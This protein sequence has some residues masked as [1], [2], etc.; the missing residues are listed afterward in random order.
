MWL[1]RA[2]RAPNGEDHLP[3][4][5]ADGG[6]KKQ[7]L[8]LGPLELEAAVEW[9]DITDE[10][11]VPFTLA[12]AIDGVGALQFSTAIY[13]SGPVPSPSLQDLS[14]LL[15]DFRRSQNLREPHD[16]EIESGNLSL[17]G[18]S[19]RSEGDFIRVWYVSDGFNFVLATYVCEWGYQDKELAQCKEIVRSIRFVER[20]AKE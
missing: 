16:P 13:K 17:V 5:N 4:T 9:K 6:M 12:R 10:G 1:S 15:E 14:S 18:S 20:K 2:E 8:S 7:V 11:D 19:F 3:G